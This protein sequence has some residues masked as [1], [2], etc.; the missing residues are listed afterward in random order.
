MKIRKSL[1]NTLQG[2]LRFILGTSKSEPCTENPS[3]EPEEGPVE[4]V[5]TVESTET[6]SA[7]IIEDDDKVETVVEEPIDQNEVFTACLNFLLKSNM[8]RMNKTIRMF[9][10][11]HPSEGAVDFY[12]LSEFP[13][14]PEV[15]DFATKFFRFKMKCGSHIF[16]KRLSKLV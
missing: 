16:I 15:R 7:E 6:A 8:L 9:I 2:L 3:S 13:D 11:T 10:N 4:Q 12:L 5:R 14:T 1:L